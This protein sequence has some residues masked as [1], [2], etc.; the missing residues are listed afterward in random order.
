MTDN[1]KHVPP[2]ETR[3]TKAGTFR[4]TPYAHRLIALAV[5]N[6]REQGRDATKGGMVEQAIRAMYGELDKS[7]GES[8]PGKSD[9]PLF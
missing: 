2:V 9:R 3:E 8:G 5:N 7:G 6:A 1:P 4:L